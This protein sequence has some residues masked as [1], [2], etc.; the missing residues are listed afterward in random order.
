[1]SFADDV[2]KKAEPVRRAILNHPFVTGIGDGTL[3]VEKF[4][5]Y[6]RQDYVYLVDYSRVLA[7]A[8]A[9]AQDLDTMGWFARLLH[10]TLNTEMGLHRS[11]CAQLCITVDQF[12]S[13]RAA[14]TTLSYTNFLLNV[15]YQGSY[16]EL[17]AS[18]LPCQWGYWEIG[19]H[20]ACKGEPA[21]APLYSQWIRMYISP[22]YKSLADWAR[23]LV[24]RLAEQSS[25]AEVARMQETYLTS[26]KYEYLFWDMA[27]NMETWPV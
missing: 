11:Y 2:E 12:D 27:Y 6:V 24:N 7:L 3:D 26:C 4:K 23:S 19:S 21:E 9:R 1:M 14:P 25:P 17:A 16:S 5:F 20:L 10:E 13:P 15:A 22:E 18:F 8:S